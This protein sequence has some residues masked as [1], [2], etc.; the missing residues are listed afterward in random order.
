M[1]SFLL[2]AIILLQGSADAFSQS[3]SDSIRRYRNNYKNEF[4]KEE[5]SPLKKE[6]T[7]FIRFFPPSEKFRVLAD[8]RPYK[9]SSFFEMP[10]SSGKKK[11]YKK[12]GTAYFNIA[13]GKYK[14][15]IYQSRDL[16]AQ[17]QY[18]NYI[19]IPFKDR[20]NYKSTYGGGRYLDLDLNDIQDGKIMLDFNKAYNPYCA[21]S[22]G[23]NCPVPPD[24][25]RLSVSVKAGE[26]TF[27]KEKDDNR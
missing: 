26:K 27:V 10:T 21:Y 13:S 2:F 9:D 22:D 1:R 4:L 7:A 17:D 12:I 8:F 6:D 20:T 18:R 5:S 16:A 19:F 23:Y 11:V 25:N 15:H 3:Y 24:E 14:L